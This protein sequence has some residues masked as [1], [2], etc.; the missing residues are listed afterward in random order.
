M[1]HF[2]R[3]DNQGIVLDVIVVDNIVLL[4]ESGNEVEAKGVAFCQTLMPGTWVQTSYNANMRKR[5]AGIGYT[6]RSD[7]DA[8]IT[9]QPFPSWSL[10]L[11][12]ADWDAPVPKPD[13]GKCYR[14]DEATLSWVVINRPQA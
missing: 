10:N 7:I 9:P 1:A 12:T 2:A 13:D 8:F 11:A 4:D 3:I 5:Y 14:W 6:Y